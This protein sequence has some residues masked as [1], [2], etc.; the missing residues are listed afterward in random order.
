MQRFCGKIVREVG[1][2]QTLAAALPSLVPEKQQ[3][4]GVFTV[5]RGH[6]GVPSSDALYSCASLLCL[7]SPLNFQVSPLFLL[8]FTEFSLCII[9]FLEKSQRCPLHV[10]WDVAVG[11]MLKAAAHY[12]RSDF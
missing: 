10:I 9:T 2:F 12:L 6:H 3:Q 7:F 8:L 4:P 5:L 11:Q 1:K